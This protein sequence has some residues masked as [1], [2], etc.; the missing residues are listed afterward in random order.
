[1]D[2]RTNIINKD[3][4]PD[5]LGQEKSKE[6]IKS[7]LLLNRHILILGPP[8]VGKTTMAKSIAKLLPEITANKCEF[9]CDPKNPLC[10]QCKSKKNISTKKIK[11]EERFIRIQGSPDLT[12]EDLLGDIDPVKALHYGASSI[13][14]FTPGKIF[15]ANNGVLFFD[16]VNRCPEKLQN[17]LLQVLEEGKATISSYS[18]DIPANFIF[19]GTL[20]PEETAATEKLSDVF[21]DRF[22][23]IHMTYPENLE[24]EKKI[25]LLKGKKLEV[26]FPEELLNITIQF[27]RW[28]RELKE[29]QK[30]PGVRASLGLYERSQAN[31][32]LRNSKNVEINDITNVIISVLSHRIELKPSIKYLQTTEE[33]ISEEYKKFSKEIIKEK[34]SDYL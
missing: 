28:L 13:E 2:F 29:L 25:V 8:G 10:P 22:D 23:T 9:N 32:L 33:F 24:I 7:A 21:L 3:A 11:G 1:M 12:V 14:A 27:I 15:K 6:Q 5:I 26:E 30:K 19:I 34:G 18:I 16:E 20:N 31:A 4:L 17:S